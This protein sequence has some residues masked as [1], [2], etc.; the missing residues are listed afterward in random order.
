[1]L[2]ALSSRATFEFLKFE[3]P[4]PVM[5]KAWSKRDIMYR[6]MFVVQRKGFESLTFGVLLSLV[7]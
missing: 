1:M 4:V 2:G 7:F 6:T 5:F 3:I